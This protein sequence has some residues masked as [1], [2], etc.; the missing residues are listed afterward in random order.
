M[1]LD[2]KIAGGTIV[3]GTGAPR[4]NGDIGIRGGRV[5]E[6]G[7]VSSPAARTIDADGALVTP[8]FVDMH[9]H[10]DAQVLWD[11]E[12][13]SSAR[14]GVTTAVMGNCGVGCAPLAPG[15]E[16]WIASLLEGVEDIP[17][18][19]LD[20]ALDWD[21][22]SFGSYLD[23]VAEQAHTV[24][25][26][27]N[28]AHAPIRLAVMG[29]RALDGSP[30]TTEDIAAM[31]ALLHEALAAGASAFS[32][33]RISLHQMAGGG[34][35]PDWHAPRE[36]VLALSRTLA[37]FPGRPLQYASDYGMVET[38]AETRRELALLAEITA[39]G[40]PAYTPMQQYPIEG[41]WRRLVEDIGRI[42]ARG[43][44]IKF[45]AGVRAIGALLGLEALIHPFSRHPSYM[46]IAGMPLDQRVA[47]MREP[48]FRARLLA[49][50][51]RL[52]PD[53]ERIRRRFDQLERQADKIFV[54]GA[55]ADYEPDPST[56]IKARALREGKTLQEVFYEALTGGDGRNMLY[57]PL[58][59]LTGGTLDEQ[60]EIL[61]LP[62]TLMSF[63]DAGAHLAQICDA[64][65]SSYGL[66]HWGR[67]R[68]QGLP[69][70]RLVHQM[71]GAQAEL[72]GFA[73]RGVIRLGSIADIN[74]I[75]HA[76]L[77]LEPP[78][79]LHDIPGGGG[80]LMQC[81][82]G[83]VATLVGGAPIV[84]RDVLTGARPGE[85]LRS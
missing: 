64:A 19:A 13:R 70:E 46:A 36:E 65:Y 22:G 68:A 9:T 34:H 59:N 83:Y 60:R 27:A 3:D 80:R 66:L 32:T 57:L 43:A 78:E 82:T 79:M 56:S 29:E 53:E 62:D 55:E 28:V 52:G 76:A 8:G 85:V 54:M 2:L 5:V 44:T 81:A 17:S 45:E 42:Q 74:V 11:G 50:S 16:G 41:G 69:L 14:N 10:Y 33:D 48:E 1:S 40:V 51:P 38:E 25:L 12:L 23:R 20:V 4:F 31:Q 77:K 30:P 49:E 6:L 75:D 61:A 71:T 26:A 18:S 39:M 47:K 37:V 73:G 15:M 63:G 35:V 21:W 7:S 72:F 84:E 24:N 67:D 58:I